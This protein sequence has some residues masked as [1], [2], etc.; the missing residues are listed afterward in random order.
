MIQTLDEIVRR[1]CE[2]GLEL[3]C[4]EEFTYYWC[5]LFMALELAYKTSINI[6]TNQTPAII[7]KGW[8]P[9]VTQDSLMK[10]LVV[11]HPPVA[12]LK[13]ILEKAINN[14]VRFMEDSFT[15][16]KDKWHKSHVTQ[17][18]KLGK[19]VLSSTSIFYNIKG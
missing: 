16:S 3:K 2:Y 13:E 15:Y 9:R 19:L 12:S 11:I 7:E 10:D 6:N 4:C 18:F 14:A 8:N 1:F 5:I 17:D